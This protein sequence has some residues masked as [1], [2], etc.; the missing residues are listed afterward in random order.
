M[1][2]PLLEYPFWGDLRLSV[3]HF[4]E[5]QLVF[6]PLV[7]IVQKKVERKSKAFFLC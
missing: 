4:P 7:E 5:Q 1:S 6:E 2:I 3:V